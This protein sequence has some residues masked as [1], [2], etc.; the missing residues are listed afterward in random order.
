MAATAACS[1]E[2]CDPPPNVGAVLA[3][4]F[5]RRLK[6]EGGRGTGSRQQRLLQWRRRHVL[7]PGGIDQGA[8]SESGENG[9]NNLVHPS[10][11]RTPNAAKGRHKASAWCRR[12]SCLRKHAHL[13]P[14]LWACA[15]GVAV[16]A[17]RAPPL[18]NMKIVGRVQ[19]DHPPDQQG[20]EPPPL[21]FTFE[22]VED[23]SRIF[24]AGGVALWQYSRI[25]NTLRHTIIPRAC[26][27]QM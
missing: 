8:R 12:A 17:T 5:V 9:A 4:A 19:R 6:G 27:A 10:L 1:T 26:A 22:I 24:K 16:C 23:E 15:Q 18:V 3:L 2:R 25:Y 20:S 14:A 11:F 7:R 21:A 13:F